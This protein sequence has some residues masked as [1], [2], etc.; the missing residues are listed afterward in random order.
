MSEIETRDLS[1]DRHYQE[2]HTENNPF[3][4]QKIK[5]GNYIS[6]Q[7]GYPFNSQYFNKNKVGYPLIRIRDL[8]K[9]ETEA[10]YGGPFD[11]SYLAQKGAILIG[12]DGEFNA[13]LWSGPHGLLNQRVCKI[14]SRNETIFDNKYLYYTIHDILRKIESKTPI[15]TVKHLSTGSLR[16]VLISLPTIFEQ[17]K[18]AAILSSVDAAIEQTDAIIA[19]TE[20][21]KA[22]L[23]QELLA[24]EY[25]VVKLGDYTFK[26]DYGYTTS[27]IFQSV[28]PKFLRIT[29]I[30]DDG[31]NWANVP[32]CNCSKT[33]LEKY[34]LKYG[35]ILLARIG[36]TT[37]KSYLF[38]EEVKSIF[39]SYL[40]RIRCKSSLV[41]EYLHQFIK[42]PTYWKQIDA[43]KSGRLK[44]GINI[45]ILRNLL[46]PLPSIQEQKKIASITLSVDEKFEA[47]KKFREHLEKLKKGLMQ[48]L[49]TGKVRVK[50]DDHA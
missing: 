21:M 2:N 35:D 12:M 18:I 38:K 29:D 4:W 11:E 24:R 45:P 7:T 9:K 17:R 49:L 8:G 46:V 30:K 3:T 15:T 19:Q 23:M 33:I 47:E 27:A 28:G 34:M 14:L 40:I 41:P 10:Y 16:D 32:Y 50:V 25:D 6:I 26:P 44:E 36:A 20:R 42:T 37:G 1:A 39:A 31:V 13:Y 5:L 48:D 43:N 22:G